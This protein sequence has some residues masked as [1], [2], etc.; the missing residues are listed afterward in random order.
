MLETKIY[1]GLNDPDSN[2]QRFNTEKYVGVL[3]NV[4]AN[5]GVA[6]SVAM[7]RGGYFYDSGDYTLE[8]S[9]VLTLIDTEKS[10]VDNIARDL[11]AFFRQESVLITENEINAYYINEALE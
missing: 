4:C 5:Y 9:L 7:S 2:D 1:V 8:N 11:C 6:F 3:E 10:K